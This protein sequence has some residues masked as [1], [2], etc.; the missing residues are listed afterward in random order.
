MNLKKTLA[1]ISIAALMSASLVGC[2]STEPT[3]ATT[4]A[5][6]T[7]AQEV[8][9]SAKADDTTVASSSEESTTKADK[10]DND[11]NKKEEST[12]ESSETTKA[13]G[14]TKPGET[15]K[16]N[17][18][19]SSAGSTTKP[20]SSQ[21]N[22]SSTKAPSKKP[23]KKPTQPTTEKPKA[24]PVKIVLNKN[25]KA[26]CSSPYVTIQPAT[27]KNPVG[28]VYIEKGDSYVITSDTDV[29]HGQIVLKLKNTEK[30]ELRFENVKIETSQSNA[31]KIIDTSISAEREFI[32]ADA[33][34]TNANVD[35][36]SALRDDMKEVSKWDMAPNVDLSFPTGTSSSFQSNSNALS[37]VIY[38]ESKLTIKGN[39]KVA[40]K[41]VQNRNNAICSTK[42]VTFKNVTASLSTPANTSTS[43]L[44]SARGIFSFSTVK[45][46]S[47]SLSIASNGDCIR[48]DDFE[49]KGGKAVLKSSA[50]D[51]IDADDSI[52]I[53][54]GSVSVTAL[55]KSSFKVRRI[56]NEELYK[57]GDTSIKA[58]DRVEDP[59]KHTFKINGGTVVGESK[60]ITT[61][62]GGSQAS[63]TCKSVKKN[64][65]GTSA[66][67][68]SKTPVKFTISG[69]NKSSANNCIKY[70]YSS[71]A[72]KSSGS[73][74]VSAVSGKTKFGSVKV[75]FT[76]NVG[77]AE[78]YTA[79]AKS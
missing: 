39:G 38:N 14:T 55:D 26:T 30:A 49:V 66:Q 17:N 13:S 59:A 76:N 3:D 70:I 62:K 58:N 9:N 72:V 41:S 40:V 23:T 29:W 43:S 71:S 15:T 64:G 16:A 31:I 21:A 57:A 10:K 32:E 52:I 63:I 20:G 53:S 7:Q 11:K 8:D 34:S 1:I 2:T 42:S 79:Q 46:E 5:Q 44:G 6:A 73:Y 68:M 12:E 56:N 47:G 45:V 37:G 75:K 28:T 24:D 50:A 77:L 18:T 48:C 25:G 65:S 74:T 67:E 33:S 78:I 61:V 69:I 27:M 22:T 60:N 4:E 19:T 51:G 35:T 54:A 36:D